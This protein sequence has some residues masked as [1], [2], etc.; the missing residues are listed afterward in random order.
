MADP[1]ISLTY[2]SF[3]GGSNTDWSRAISIDRTANRYFVTGI[4]YSADYPVTPGAFDLDLSSLP[5]CADAF[6]SAFDV[7]DHSL[8]CS[9]Y[10]GGES[11]D[12]THA[13]IVDDWGN[14]YI[15]GETYSVDLPTTPGAFDPTHNGW[16]IEGFVASLTPELD[17]VRWCTYIGGNDTDEVR[18]L[19]FD[20]M[21]FVFVGGYMESEEFPFD[22]SL[23]PDGG[24]FVAKF[25]AANGALMWC[26]S[27]AIGVVCSMQL[28]PSGQLIV[29]GTC[30]EALTSEGAYDTSLNGHRDLFVMCLD[31]TD[32]RFEWGTYLGGSD[33]ELNIDILAAENGDI[34]FTTTTESDD[35]PLSEAG[36]GTDLPGGGDVVVG[37]LSGDGSNLLWSRSIGGSGFEGS[38]MSRISPK[39]AADDRGNLLVVTQTGSDDLATTPASLYPDTIGGWDALM[40]S[41]S[42]DGESCHWVTYL[43]S[44]SW[45]DNRD[46]VLIP[47]GIIVVG[48]SGGAIHPPLLPVTPDAFDQTR[49][50]NIDAYIMELADPTIVGT[51]I[52]EATIVLNGDDVV[53]AWRME[54]FADPG[55]ILVHVAVA[56]RGRALPVESSDG[57]QYRSIDRSVCLEGEAERSYRITYVDESGREYGLLDRTFEPDCRSYRRWSLSASASDN[58]EIA[59]T[60]RLGEP[61]TVRLEIHDVMGR[62]VATLPRAALPVGEHVLTWNGADGRGRFLPSGRYLARCVLDGRDLDT[63]FTILR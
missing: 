63:S 1:A 12:E 25:A 36:W 54:S 55:A 3:L 18:T 58:G 29:A 13:M 49:V 42:A 39:L 2:C 59:F 62:R 53:L 22:F 32:G 51:T 52:A 47:S 38:E 21:G 14:V 48:N 16:S 7:D 44:G 61:S 15:G 56:G 19:L 57:V 9:T 6:V 10:F 31:K 40:V 43:G 50:D 30:A 24:G 34:H 26:G 23:V 60:L 8:C 37:A 4:T 27:V 33:W 20:P 17:D 46:L 5:Y 45:D 28:S 41:M 35:F 11:N